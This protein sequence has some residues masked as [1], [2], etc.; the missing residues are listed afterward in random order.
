M[1]TTKT[2]QTVTEATLLLLVEELTRECV[3]EQMD[4]EEERLVKEIE[5]SLCKSHPGNDT[6]LVYQHAIHQHAILIITVLS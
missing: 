2:I 6:N 5:A 1:A 4:A 3:E